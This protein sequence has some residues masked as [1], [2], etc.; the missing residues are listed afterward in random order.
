MHQQQKAGRHRAKQGG[1]KSTVLLHPALRVVEYS[2]YVLGT[3]AR[4]CVSGGDG[5]SAFFTA[6]STFDGYD[7]TL[8]TE[9]CNYL[10][11]I[12]LRKREKQCP[13]QESGSGV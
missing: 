2:I 8:T 3:T 9:D 1:C 6:A 5:V 11:T 10:Y 13:R 7:G 12:S 4:F